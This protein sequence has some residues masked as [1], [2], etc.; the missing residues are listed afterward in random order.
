MTKRLR[1]IRALAG[2]LGAATLWPLAALGAIT[3]VGPAQMP[4]TVQ[5][6]ASTTMLLG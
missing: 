2:A 1:L 6:S 4:A 3:A 5:K